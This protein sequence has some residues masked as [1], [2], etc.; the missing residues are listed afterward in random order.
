MKKEVPFKFEKASAADRVPGLS[1]CG[2]PQ[3]PGHDGPVVSP[4]DQEGVVFCA[5]VQ[6]ER[7]GYNTQ[8]K[9]VLAVPLLGGVCLV[10][11]AQHRQRKA[12]NKMGDMKGRA[13]FEWSAAG[14]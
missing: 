14:L 4:C 10:A 7:D 13:S 9:F 2:F 3:K 11:F 5:S 6:V 12:K 8:Q 1:L